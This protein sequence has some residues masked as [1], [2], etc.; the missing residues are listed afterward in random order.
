[1]NLNQAEAL[2]IKIILDEVSDV[3]KLI[4]ECRNR[5]MSCLHRCRLTDTVKSAVS[6]AESLMDTL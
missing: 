5:L 6:A 1:M 2:S 3:Y 4:L